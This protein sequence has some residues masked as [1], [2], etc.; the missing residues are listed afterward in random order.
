M[1]IKQFHVVYTFITWYLFSLWSECSEKIC[2]SGMWLYSWIKT[3]AC[4][5]C[6]VLR[7]WLMEVQHK[8]RIHHFRIDRSGNITTDHT[9]GEMDTKSKLVSWCTSPM[10]ETHIHQKRLLNVY[11][12][13]EPLF[14]E[15]QETKETVLNSCTVPHSRKLSRKKTFMNFVVL[16]LFAKVFAAKFW[17]SASFGTANASNPRKFSPWKLYFSL[18]HETFLPQKFPAVRYAKLTSV[19]CQVNCML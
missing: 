14:C 10:D 2:S 1:G 19:H 6:K 5:H 4:D 8:T 3:K 18:I 9:E 15:H 17:G 16:W 12:K 11:I 13:T 7:S